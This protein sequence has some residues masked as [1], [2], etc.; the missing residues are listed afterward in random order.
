M[1]QLD[2]A[3]E[4]TDG[5]AE[6]AQLAPSRD[7]A[8]SD[9]SRRNTPRS[10][11]DNLK[12]ADA[13]SYGTFSTGGV[14]QRLFEMDTYARSLKYYNYLFMGFVVF[15]N[16]VWPIGWLIG[17]P[18][19][20]YATRS[21]DK[22][23]SMFALI[24]FIAFI[25][26]VILSA[27]P[28]IAIFLRG[29]EDLHHLEDDVRAAKGLLPLDLMDLCS[30]EIM[31][32][33]AVIYNW[34]Y[35]ESQKDINYMKD[36]VLKN[37]ECRANEFG[38]HAVDEEFPARSPR[39]D[40]SKGA[41]HKTLSLAKA[42]KQ[43][44]NS[45]P[46]SQLVHCLCQLPGWEDDQ[47]LSVLDWYLEVCGES[48]GVF[49]MMSKLHLEAEAGEVFALDIY[50]AREQWVETSFMTIYTGLYMVLCQGKAMIME[51]TAYYR[52]RWGQFAVLV[53]L[54]LIRAF[55][56]RLWHKAMHGGNLFPQ[57]PFIF[58]V[59]LD[60]LL[61]SFCVSLLWLMLVYKVLKMYRRTI[62]QVV[63]LTALVD[64]R[65]R[66]LYSG[67]FLQSMFWY[68]LPPEQVID[69]LGKLPLLDLRIAANAATFWHLR[70]FVT[71]SHSDDIMAAST[72]L[73][74][75]VL[76]LCCKFLVTVLVVGCVLPGAVKD[77]MCRKLPPIMIVTIFDLVV[78]GS[79]AMSVLYTAM[80]VNSLLDSHKA[81][82]SEA[83]YE[84][85]LQIATLHHR[86]PDYDRKIEDRKVARRI[87]FEEL[88]MAQQY[89]SREHIFFG[90]EI[91]PGKVISCAA[92]AVMAVMAL[93]QEML[94]EA[95]IDNTEGIVNVAKNATAVFLH[96]H[97]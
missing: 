12:V 29:S 55:L 76:W 52:H 49:S 37:W 92:S 7:D 41:M 25:I 30:A 77:T 43:P 23:A 95:K 64:P 70:D 9:H 11:S 87:L 58:V 62:A 4:K 38:M 82:L 40:H 45:L 46:L 57:G 50:V 18:I 39:L 61:V 26:G 28:V 91:T 24:L 47:P 36:Q 54:A 94:H 89:S 33:L 59:V 31:L 67:S 42:G 48:R 22:M 3:T 63:I 10:C 60:N 80:K 5:P 66:M 15:A 17:I 68:G 81:M 13:E 27:V 65:K 71:L 21:H 69:V 79:M 73:E 56:P 32:L 8:S 2:G 6:F 97:L 20:M 16:L 74:I 14:R 75:V 88:E 19:W 44:G 53:S 85:T 83:K 96:Q 93:V 51:L 35:F 86:D 34:T 72:L 84:V 90:M 1:A 78:F